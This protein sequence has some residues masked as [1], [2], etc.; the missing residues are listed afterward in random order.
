MID[1]S[2]VRSFVRGVWKAGAGLN[3]HLPPAW[4]CAPGSPACERGR[5]ERARARARAMR[6]SHPRRGGSREGWGAQVQGGAA[7]ARRGR[8]ADAGA[9]AARPCCCCCCCCCGGRRCRSLAL[10]CRPRCWEG[11]APPRRRRTRRRRRRMAA[12]RAAASTRAPLAG[13]G[14]RTGGR[15]LRGCCRP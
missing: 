12:G 9:A 13:G 7:T 4:P 15:R 10:A 8:D 11:A 2:I 3:E 6:A 14:D 5:D 1:R